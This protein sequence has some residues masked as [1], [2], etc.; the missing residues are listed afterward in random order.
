MEFDLSKIITICIENISTFRF[1]SQNQTSNKI[2][3]LANYSEQKTIKNSRNTLICKTNRNNRN[4]S[5]P[6]NAPTF[7]YLIL[8]LFIWIPQHDKGEK[9]VHKKWDY[10]NVESGNVCQLFH[11]TPFFSAL[12]LKPLKMFLAGVY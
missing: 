6:E 3:E 11:V 7:I 4:E 2:P 1:S 10:G 5:T 8:V 12:S 9:C